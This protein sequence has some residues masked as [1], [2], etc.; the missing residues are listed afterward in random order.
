MKITSFNVLISIFDNFQCLNI[1]EKPLN[2]NKKNLKIVEYVLTICKAVELHHIT[3]IF[4]SLV[5]LTEK[6]NHKTHDE[7]ELM[8]RSTIH[9]RGKGSKKNVRV[10]PF[11]FDGMSQHRYLCSRRKSYFCCY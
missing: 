10:N 11:A 4:V 6:K 1:L 8:V 3:L 2:L 5:S 7:E 9:D